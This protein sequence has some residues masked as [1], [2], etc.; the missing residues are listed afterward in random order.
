MIKTKNGETTIKG[1]FNEIFLDLILI[2]N[3]FYENDDDF[4]K[5][6]IYEAIDI[7]FASENEIE[8]R[9]DEKI[10]LEKNIN[11]FLNELLDKLKK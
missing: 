4:D 8:K 11:K 10:G 6:L 7:G 5:D 2:A 9:L 3:A 1:N